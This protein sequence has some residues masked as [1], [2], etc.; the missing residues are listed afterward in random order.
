MNFVQVVSRR[1][2]R[3]DQECCQA[4]MQMLLNGAIPG[5]QKPEKIGPLPDIGR[6][7]FGELALNRPLAG[8]RARFAAGSTS[9]R[10]LGAS[11]HGRVQSHI[12]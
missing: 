9:P 10:L 7:P 1:T 4:A 2:R 11:P 3:Y 8:L 12:M 6:L 5:A